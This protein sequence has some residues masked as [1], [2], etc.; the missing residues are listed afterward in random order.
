MMMTNPLL[1]I[2]IATYNRA[3]YIGK[4]L[5]SI[6]PQLTEEVE[7][8]IV[9]GASPD[10]TEAVARGYAEAC[11]QI[12]YIR[13]PAKGG[14]DHDYCQAVEAAK[15][16]YCW[17][18]SDDDLLKPGAVA[19]VL[20]HIREGHS[21]IIVNADVMDQCFS[22]VL[23]RKC[24]KIDRDEIVAGNEI[25]RLFGIAG[26]YM[27]FIGGVVVNRDFWVRRGK[28]RYFGTELVHIGVVFQSPLPSSTLVIAEPYITIR[29]GNAQWISRAFEV[30][31]FKW[32]NLICS[33]EGVPEHIKREYQPTQSWG[34]LR[35]VIAH[36]AN[37]AYSN[38]EYRRWFAAED[39]S[40]C[41][42]IAVRLIA[43]MPKRVLKW[44]ITLYLNLTDKEALQ[45]WNC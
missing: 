9:D 10:N 41:W 36:R 26:E 5:E 22:K 45:L 3:G 14:V 19:A 2:C 17:F 1:S 8:V 7:I 11:K 29:F 20:R 4:T 28:E 37:G 12:R 43:F 18:F 30:W 25:K 21:L 42:K 39:T 32:P 35:R 31:M 15:G 13:L 24:V 27:S 40:A 23:K 34:R 33:L 16:S 6:I 44:L 38:K